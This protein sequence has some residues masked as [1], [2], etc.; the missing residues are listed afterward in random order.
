MKSGAIAD[1]EAIAD[2]IKLSANNSPI[3]VVGHSDDA[4]SPEYNDRLA[5]ARAR[6][7]VSYL[8]ARGISMD[9]LKLKSFG[10]TQPVASN[11]TPEGRQ[12]NRRVEVFFS[13]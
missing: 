4:G 1:L 3:N 6:S 2:S 12:L 11:S 9:R 7:V 8:A 13:N 10:S 5:E